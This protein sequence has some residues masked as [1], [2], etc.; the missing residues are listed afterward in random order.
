MTARLHTTRD[1]AILW[2]IIENPA[3]LNAFTRDMWEAVPRVI[4]EADGDP[5]IRAVVFRGAGEKAFSVGADIS[6][7]A[8]N[9]VGEAAKRYDEINHAAYMAI[10]AAK[11]PTIAMVHGF[12]MGG[13]LELAI[14]CDLR[15]AAEGA[16]FAVPAAKLGLGY[17]P[18]W[19]RPMLGVLSAARTKE[20]LFTGRR[21][22]TEEAL[23]IGLLNR[24]VAAEKLE[25]ET[26][27][28]AGEIAANAPLV[29]QAA[30]RAVDEMTARPESADMAALDKLVADCFASA[31][32]QEGW[33]AFLEKRKPRF[34]GR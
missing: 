24:V 15:L 34:S 21:V 10:L 7:F 19:I 9:R 29:V 14:C 5:D 11:T 8:E 18:R 13:A 3:R 26:R 31:D 30:K 20:L 27:T 23:A 2:A 17:N 4:A 1:G 33:Q 32:Y 22:V 6:E 28:L 25:A 16:Q 12:C